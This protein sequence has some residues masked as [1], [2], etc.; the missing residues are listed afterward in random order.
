M[1]HVS[2]GRAARDRIFEDGPIEP[3]VVRQVGEGALRSNGIQHRGRLASGIVVFGE[4]FTIDRVKVGEPARGII[5]EVFLNQL[6]RD[7]RHREEL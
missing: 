1:N 7:T 6:E 2:I 5:I 4:D 3:L